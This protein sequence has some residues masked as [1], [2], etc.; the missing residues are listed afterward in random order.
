VVIKFVSVR[1]SRRAASQCY[2]FCSAATPSSVW[3]PVSGSRSQHR[4]RE[5]AFARLIHTAE[6]I[7]SSAP[8]TCFNEDF[9]WASNIGS[10]ERS[11]DRKANKH[12]AGSKIKIISGVRKSLN[13]F[14]DLQYPRLYSHRWT[15]FLQTI[16]CYVKLV[17]LFFFCHL[18]TCVARMKVQADQFIS[19]RQ[20]SA[21]EEPKSS[22]YSHRVFRFH[23]CGRNNKVSLSF[24]TY[25]F[26]SNE[27]RTKRTSWH[28]NKHFGRWTVKKVTPNFWFA[29][30]A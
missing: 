7:E 10:K 13:R 23:T 20:T 25:H 9:P 6:T 21:L 19:S 3:N 1:W 22:C 8:A 18:S 2:G 16:P 28:R 12:V 11:N 4:N 27:K 30:R 14:K 29:C 5:T 17:R 26:I 24:H 15:D